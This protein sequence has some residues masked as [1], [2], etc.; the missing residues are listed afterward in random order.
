MTTATPAGRVRSRWYHSKMVRH[1]TLLAA[2]ALCFLGVASAQLPDQTTLNKSYN[3]RY[4]G[5]AIGSS[6]DTAVSFQGTLAFDGKGGFTVTGSG[7]SAGATLKYLTTG[8]YTVL[9]SGM[10][11]LTNP[12]ADPSSATGGATIYGGLSSTGII[13]G[14]STESLYCDLFVAVPAATSASVSTLSG[15]YKVASMEFLTGD[16]SATRDALFTVT[17]DGKGGFGNVTISGT[18]QQLLNKATTQTSTGATYTMTANGTGTAIF[19]A[20]GGSVTAAQTILSG[21]KNLFVSQDGSFFIAGN[22]TGYDFVIGIKAATGATQ[23]NGLYWSAYL[24]NYQSGGQGDGLTGAAGSANELASSGNLEIAHDRT[25]FEFEFPYDYTYS[26]VFQFDNTGSVVYSSGDFPSSYVIGSNGDIVLGAGSSF[27]Y[28]LAIYV[29]APDMKAP[30]GTTVFLNPQGIVNAANNVP[31]TTQIAPGEVISLYGTGL[32]PATAVTASAPFPSTLGG[33]QVLINGKAAPIYYSSASQVS[34]VVPYDA[35]SDGSPL[36]VQVTLNGAQ[37][38]TA[39]VYSGA[40]SPGLFTIPAGGPFPGA[41]LRQD[42][43]IMSKTNAAKIGETVSFF[44]TGLGPVT[45]AV[46][47]GA[48]AP[49]SPLSQVPQQIFVYIDGVQ[50]KVV[51]QGLAPGLGGLYQMNVT[52]PTGVSSGEVGIDVQTTTGSGNTLALDSWNFE[53]SMFIQ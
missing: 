22:P 16:F 7:T 36:T 45:P 14:S 29:K 51:Y 53:A 18:A 39:T 21:T 35:P 38:N 23:M 6:A 3:V 5:A 48:A 26:D 1:L 4:L 40:T 34:A 44:L 25:N 17:A 28:L 41:I 13:I 11:S 2:G 42:F 15:N 9:S 33:T 32:G 31:I 46:T 27:N 49:T 24:N 12:F 47:A 8:K 50:A 52:I 37:S 43:S 19:P 30:S 10:V 20:P